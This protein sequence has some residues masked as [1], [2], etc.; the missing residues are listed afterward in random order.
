V[1]ATLPR[2][3]TAIRIAPTAV[4]SPLVEA[5]ATGAR[6]SAPDA[7]ETTVTIPK[8]RPAV[9]GRTSSYVPLGMRVRHGRD[10]DQGSRPRTP[11]AVSVFEFHGDESPGGVSLGV[12]DESFDG[13][14]IHLRWHPETWFFHCGY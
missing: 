8:R 7:E 6:R 12:G 3:E 13:G 14:K 4:R 5:T 2:S 1:A 10:Q 11:H 9:R